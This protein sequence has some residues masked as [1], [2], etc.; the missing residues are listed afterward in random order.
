MDILQ[1]IKEIYMLMKVLKKKESIF[2]IRKKKKKK[3]KKKMKE[4][5]LIKIVMMILKEKK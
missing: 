3:D 4:L 1:M 5:K 2:M